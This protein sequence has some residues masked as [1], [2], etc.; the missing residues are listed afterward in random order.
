[1]N[2]ALRSLAI[3]LLGCCTANAESYLGPTAVAA[4]PDGKTLLVANA[5]GRQVVWLALPEGKPIRQLAVP[6][7]P[8]GVAVTSDGTKVLV[9]CAAPK[10]LLLVLELA[11]GKQLTAIAVG[12]TAMSPVVS[13]DGGRAY[14]CN[15]FSGDV[16][17]IDLAAGKETARVPVVREPVAAALTPDG[18]TLLVANHLPNVTL[19]DYPVASMVSVIDTATLQAGTIRLAHGTHSLRDICVSP[20]G[21]WAYVTHL[22]SNFELMPSQV[23]MGWMNI[24]CISVLD[25]AQRKSI[26]TL[27]LDEL[28]QASGNPWGVAATADGKW[29]C[30]TH[31]GTH[32][33]NV[34]D[35]EAARGELVRT[36]ISGSVG[37]ILDDARFAT[38]RR[39]RIALPGKGPRGV[40]LVGHRAYVAQYYSDSVA[41][42]DLDAP[43][44]LKPRSVPLGPEPQP[45]LRRRGEML[46]N[47][48]T[49]CRQQWQSCASCHPDGR[50]D[51][52]NW[53]LM[54]DGFGNTKNTKS[55]VLAFQT[56]PSMFEAVRDTPQDAVRAGLSGILF[57]NSTEE[58]A[59]AVDAYLQ[60][61]APVPS[62]R[63]VDGRLSAAA[64]R[65]KTLFEGNRTGCTR[66][67]PAPLF[68]DLKRH[69]VNSRDRYGTTEQFDTPTLVEVWRTAPYLHDGRYLTIR[70]LLVDGKHGRLGGRMEDLGDRELDD[71][72]EYVLSL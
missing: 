47:D 12:H 5:D 30:I 2:Y 45:S 25:L 31:A 6:H 71:L 21:R 39:R 20:D 1:M 24:N 33:M 23:E 43:E 13:P 15:R 68:T 29:V 65:G 32:E 17:V 49:I 35:A 28:Y 57:A 9:T 67:H 3:V 70:A 51:V 16:S 46:F 69:N 14:V 41:I 63:L 8:T 52:L 55:L 56:P 44:E 36:Y 26:N 7:E 19:Q 54:N 40:A 59:L 61:L 42:A 37:A 48:A 50:A 38:S 27:G 34:I 66:C 22:T 58:D 53:D 4:A 62:P 10:S 18:K 11:T 60:S 72:V 64:E